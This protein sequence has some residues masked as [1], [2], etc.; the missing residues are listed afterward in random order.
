VIATGYADEPRVPGLAASAPGNVLQLHSS[1]YRAP[2]ELPAGGVIVVGAGP[3]GQQ[4]AAELRRAGRD[5]TIAVGRHAHMPR[6]YR[7]KD[8]WHWL[9]LTGHIEQT[10]ADA[11][12]ERDASQSLSLV[13]SGADGG[14]Q[15]DL[16]V[17]AGL[18]VTVTGR[19]RGFVGRHA[20]FGDDL[21]ATIR[22]TEAR[23]RRGLA[24][25]DWHVEG[26]PH[27]ERPNAQWIPP[28]QV[29]PGLRTLD[30]EAAGI[31]TVIWAT[32]YGRSY[33]WLNL[34]VLDGQGEIVH[35]RG[36]TAVKGL[37][38]LGLRFQHRRKSHFIGGVGED[39]RFVAA[40]ILA[41]PRRHGSVLGQRETVVTVPSGAT[42]RM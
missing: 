9:A 15:L 6:R 20:I 16:G 4:L 41:R 35:R 1:R 19:L 8:I 7:G 2:E 14:E 26:I 24:R 34:D 40:R 29:P 21:E 3:S 13:L 36:V 27:S 22:A 23:M 30:L 5:V 10:L 18:G 37:Y 42:R 17:L 28:M 38:A 12:H 33:P 11:P 25:I 39:A 32:G 31:S